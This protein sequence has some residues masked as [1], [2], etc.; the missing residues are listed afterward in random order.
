MAFIVEEAGGK[1]TDGKMRL[2]EKVPTKLHERTPIFIGSADD[3][4][5]LQSFLDSEPEQ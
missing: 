5:I 4:D 2:L 1:A 3:I